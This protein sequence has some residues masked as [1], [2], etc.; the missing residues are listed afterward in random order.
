MHLFELRKG[1]QS[2]PHLVLHI[3]ASSPLYV[4]QRLR[5]HPFDSESV[6]LIDKFP[7]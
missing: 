7:K 3:I 5:L 2:C 6:S 4:F 1:M